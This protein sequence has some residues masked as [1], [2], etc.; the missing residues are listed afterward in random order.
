MKGQTHAAGDGVVK[1][2]RI[3]VHGHIKVHDF[4]IHDIVVHDSAYNTTSRRG[5]A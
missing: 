1:Y 2:G 3:K 5:R 4:P